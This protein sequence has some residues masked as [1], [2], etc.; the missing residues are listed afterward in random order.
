ML[1][2]NS[3]HLLPKKK[4]LL[5]AFD[6]RFKVKGP[7]NNL[8]ITY[9]DFIVW[10]WWAQGCGNYAN[11]ARWFCCSLSTNEPNA[12]TEYL[13]K[14]K[15]QATQVFDTYLYEDPDLYGWKPI[16]FFKINLVLLYVKTMIDCCVWV[17][18]KECG[19]FF[20]FIPHQEGD[21]RNLQSCKKRAFWLIISWV[22]YLQ[23]SG[24]ALRF[25]RLKN[26][27]PQI[28]L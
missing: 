9:I 25:F 27:M 19:G 16:R 12:Y 5:R 11:T 14:G 18:T 26:T 8:I 13:L 2:N 17:V 6:A 4:P 24:C 21:K 20:M 28:R 15:P 1:S 7:Q 22:L 23:K 3:Q 10:L